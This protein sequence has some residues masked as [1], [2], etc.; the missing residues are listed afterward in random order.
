MAEQSLSDQAVVVEGL[1]KSFSSKGVLG[2]SGA[3][4]AVDDVSF[5]V[6]RSESLA[7]VGESGSG[8]TTV[9]RCLVGLETP[10]AGTVTICGKV[11]SVGRVSTKQRRRR[12]SE[13]QLVFQDPY[14]SLDPRQKIGDTLDEALAVH[15]GK[16]RSGDRVGRT[17]E[18]L[19][20]VGLP[21]TVVD[22]YPSVL[23]GGQRQRVAIARAMA[24]DPQVIV[25]DESVASLDVS[26][27][28]QMLNLISDLREATGVTTI[29]I[30]HDLAVVRQV[31]ERVIVMRRGRIVEEGTTAAVL[32]QPSNSYTR[33]LIESVPTVGWNPVDVV[34]A[35]RRLQHQDSPA[36]GGA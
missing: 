14:L 3:P 2:D 22:S 28:A 17:A 35:S 36:D 12:A 21:R 20:Q 1:S 9:A 13:A 34:Q 5:S 31:S 15:R 25:F 24:A 6:G 30:S 7:I 10:T 32:G 11:R 27:Q 4:K 23:S 26:I 33:L 29:F 18:L 16:L 19:E 8:K